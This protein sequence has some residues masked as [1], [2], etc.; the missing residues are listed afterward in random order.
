M[1]RFYVVQIEPTL[2]GEA[3]LVREW[4]RIGRGGQMLAATYQ[5]RATAEAAFQG[6][7][8]TKRRRGYVDRG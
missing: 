6:I 7:V 1:K 5:D 2:F 4:G 8:S 3:Q